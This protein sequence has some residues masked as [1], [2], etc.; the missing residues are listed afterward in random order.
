MTTMVA[1]CSSPC[2]ESGS[3]VESGSED[4]NGSGVYRIAYIARAQADSF[5]A[6]LANAVMEEAENMMILKLMF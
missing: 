4:S 5:A 3:E 2:H 6:W 1:G